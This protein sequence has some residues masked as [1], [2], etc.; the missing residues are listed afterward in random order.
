M[1]YFSRA[2]QGSLGQ[3]RARAGQRRAEQQPEAGLEL[4]L[5]GPVQV[6]SQLSKQGH[7]RSCAHC[8]S[9]NGG[10]HATEPSAASSSI[11]SFLKAAC[12][13]HT[14]T[15]RCTSS[16][17]GTPSWLKPLSN[18][19]RLSTD[20]A[21]HHLNSVSSAWNS[22]GAPSFMARGKKVPT[23]TSKYHLMCWID[24]KRPY[25]VVRHAPAPE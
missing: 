3:G 15:A 23:L 9:A 6:S 17:V 21:A 22:A 16:Q 4:G 11:R 20:A 1:V 7:P 18:S 13:R 12:C 2:G 8:A 24:S 25:L 19:T 10:R 5:E 14:W